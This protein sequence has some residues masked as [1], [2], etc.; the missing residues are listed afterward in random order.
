M[1]NAYLFD[2]HLFIQLRLSN[3]Y[4]NKRVSLTNRFIINH[5]NTPLTYN[6]GSRFFTRS[7]TAP[8]RRPCRHRPQLSRRVPRRDPAAALDGTLR[9]WGQRPLS[10]KMR[11]GESPE[12]TAACAIRE[13]LSERVRVRILG[14]AGGAEAKQRVEEWESASYPASPPDFGFSKELLDP[15]ISTEASQLFNEGKS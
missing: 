6:G 8:R 15:A 12:A 5:Q 11:P 13:E 7:G 4:I 2:F 9:R 14:G 10:E 1:S 3:M